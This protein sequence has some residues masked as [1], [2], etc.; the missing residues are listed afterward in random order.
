MVGKW[1][2]TAQE[3]YF[4]Y[5]VKHIKP[6]HTRIYI[7]N[8]TLNNYE[9]NWTSNLQ[10]LGTSQKA[11]FMMLDND[12]WKT[13]DK[14]VKKRLTS[15]V[16][17]KI[18]YSKKCLPLPPKKALKV[19]HKMC[20]QINVWWNDSL[21]LAIS[22]KILQVYIFYKKR[23]S[24]KHYTIHIFMKYRQMNIWWGEWTVE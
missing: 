4:L 1:I 17:V 23:L 14:W 2:F 18:Q 10:F 21:S 19:H 7:F 24:Y 13:K 16:A 9:L 11:S 3:M 6:T 8:N 22:T 15:S 20:N 5:Y 12:Y